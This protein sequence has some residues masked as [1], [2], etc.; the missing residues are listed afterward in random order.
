[1]T[2]PTNHQAWS[3]VLI[4]RAGVLDGPALR[5]LAALDSRRL[6]KGSFLVAVIGGELVA[7]API[8]STSPRSAIRSVPLP[9]RHLLELQARSLRERL[10]ANALGERAA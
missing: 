6:S 5:R 2:A 4:R 1:M 9:T 10:P 7:A 3:P 8:E